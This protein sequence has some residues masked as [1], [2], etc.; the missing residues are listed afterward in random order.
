MIRTLQAPA[1]A[2][3]FGA[4]AGHGL[5]NLFGVTLCSHVR[6]PPSS[7]LLVHADQLPPQSTCEQR[8]C[9]SDIV[10]PKTKSVR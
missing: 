2:T 6:F 7:Q 8:K 10:S 4:L 5:P 1:P 3:Q 9:G